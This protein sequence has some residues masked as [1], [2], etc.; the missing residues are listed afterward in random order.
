MHT[1]FFDADMHMNAQNR[2]VVSKKAAAYIRLLIQRHF[3]LA[4]FNV[5]TR[6]GVLNLNDHSG[7]RHVKT[8]HVNISHVV[9]EFYRKAA[10]H[11][12][13]VI[14]DLMM[15]LACSYSSTWTV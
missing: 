4:L 2:Y 9:T 8:F 14:E 12:R 6:C 11:N 15:F 1:L 5:F 10:S 7:R 3:R 13:A